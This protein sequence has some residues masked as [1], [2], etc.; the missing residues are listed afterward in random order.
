MTQ[1]VTKVLS[2]TQCTLAKVEIH[3]QRKHDAACGFLFFFEKQIA[4][5]S[6]SSVASFRIIYTSVLF[7]T[8]SIDVKCVATVCLWCCDWECWEMCSRS[9]KL[10]RSRRVPAW[11]CVHTGKRLITGGSFLCKCTTWSCDSDD[12]RKRHS[13]KLTFQ[14]TLFSSLQ[15]TPE[16]WYWGW[17]IGRSRYFPSLVF[18]ILSFQSIFIFY[19]IFKSTTL[20]I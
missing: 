12:G 13:G 4:S 1:H 19:F 18:L 8:M 14:Q 15:T 3:G 20:K 6:P 7:K 11:P 9:S 10:W 16:T 17:N 5:V 2:G